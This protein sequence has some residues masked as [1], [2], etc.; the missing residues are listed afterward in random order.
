MTA[1]GQG[2]QGCQMVSFRTENPNLGNFLM[3]QEKS[4]NPEGDQRGGCC[5]FG[6]FF[7]LRNLFKIWAIFFTEKVI[8]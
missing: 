3:Y 2:D 8:H 5:T 1:A 7:T 6:R 4:G